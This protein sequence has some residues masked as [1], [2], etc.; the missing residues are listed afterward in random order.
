MLVV[1]ALVGVA[2]CTHDSSDAAGTSPADSQTLLTDLP[3]PPE[4]PAN[5]ARDNVEAAVAAYQN[6]VAVRDTVR[7]DHFRDWE[8]KVLPLTSADEADWVASFF[9]QAVE[10]G[11]YQVGANTVSHIKLAGEGYSE[12]PTGAGHE[13]VVL[14]A[15]LDTSGAQALG[16]EGQDTDVPGSRGR[17]VATVT[18]QH[19]TVFDEQGAVVEDPYDQSW[20]RVAGEDLD[21]E[22]PC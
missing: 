1:G 20:W 15:C 7:Q 19:L 8:T 14:E 16:A 6:Y 12:D 18:V 21:R 13:R 2:G 3:D 17:F 11:R 5:P 9:S 22:R 4:L 10:L